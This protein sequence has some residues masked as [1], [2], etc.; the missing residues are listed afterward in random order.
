MVLWVWVIYLVKK[1]GEYFGY[2]PG[3]LEGKEVYIIECFCLWEWCF[4]GILI[5]IIILVFVKSQS[6]IWLLVLPPLIFKYFYEIS[7]I[8][9]VWLRYDCNLLLTPFIHSLLI[10]CIILPTIIQGAKYRL[11]QFKVELMIIIGLYIS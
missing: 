6:F 4:V 2:E 7:V 9:F 8:K 3:G 10:L 5:C 11:I 1:W